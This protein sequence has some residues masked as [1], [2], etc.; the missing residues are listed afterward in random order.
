M[1]SEVVEN[2]KATEQTVGQLLPVL[3]NKK[4][5]I[6]DGRHRTKANKNWKRVEL[7]LDELRTH[8]ARLVINTQRRVAETSDY[9]ELA[10]FLCKTEPEDKSSLAER[11]SKLTGI[12]AITVRRHL[13][14]NYKQV[15]EKAD[16]GDHL[17]RTRDVAVPEVVA[18]PLRKTIDDLQEIV[19]SN[20][21][22]EREIVKKF[23]DG[24]GFATVLSKPDKGKSNVPPEKQPDGYAFFKK[25]G[26]WSN[27]AAILDK[28]PIAIGVKI[29]RDMPE[30]QRDRF[31]KLARLVLDSTEKLRKIIH[32]VTI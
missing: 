30:P 28:V 24:L 23:I 11:I 19:A 21:E 4:G 18:E 5:E 16:R 27:A 15:Q 1:S 6:I 31:M 17:Q 3:V 2:L 26:A 29:V 12:S 20:P 8:I 7:D 10:E 25:I 14:D 13:S 32:E 9:D 22:K